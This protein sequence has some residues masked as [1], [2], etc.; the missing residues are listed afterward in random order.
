MAPRFIPAGLF[1]VQSLQTLMFRRTLRNSA[2][3]ILASLAGLAV[4][5]M[6]TSPLDNII[7][8]ALFFGLALVFLISL[9]YFFVRLQTGEVTPKNRYRIATISLILIILAMFR[10]ADSLSWVDGIILILFGFGLV[11]YISRRSY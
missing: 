11:F 9:G 7:Y 8:T 5:T 10:S 3:L 1:L 4:L 2:I 6:V